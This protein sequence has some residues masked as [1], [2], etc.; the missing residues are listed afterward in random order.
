MS[1]ELND[2]EAKEAAGGRYYVNGNTK[3]VAWD[4]IPGAY[5]LKN[6]SVYDA[7]EAMD[8][9]KGTCKTQAEYDQACYDLLKSYGWI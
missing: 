8:G 1:R 6:C 4:T 2:F 9:L 5:Q 7:M 3:K